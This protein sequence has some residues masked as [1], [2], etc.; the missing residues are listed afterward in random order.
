MKLKRKV[1]E[2]RYAALLDSMYTG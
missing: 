2:Q 1:L